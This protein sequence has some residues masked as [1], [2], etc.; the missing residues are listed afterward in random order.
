MKTPIV[1]EVELGPSHIVLD[2]DPAPS[3]PP[4]KWH[5]T[6]LV[7]AHVYG[8]HGRPSELLLSTCDSWLRCYCIV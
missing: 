1:T 3:V 8:G 2:G 5:S 6:P 4:Q 7:S